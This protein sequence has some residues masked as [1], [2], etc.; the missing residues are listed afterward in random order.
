MPG[1]RAPFSHA[2]TADWLVPMAAA[3]WSLSEAGPGAGGVD[4]RGEVHRPTGVVV[5]LLVGPA[6]LVGEGGL[7]LGAGGSVIDPIA[8][9][10]DLLRSG[11]GFLGGLLLR[12][13]S[14]DG[15]VGGAPRSMS[16]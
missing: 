2:A 8:G 15:Y 7:A 4:Q 1:V 16:R 9:G 3:S 6:L 14:S 5:G 12:G 11:R 13:N 10:G